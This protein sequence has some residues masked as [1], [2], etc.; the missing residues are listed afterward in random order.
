MG[1]A[2]VEGKG[3]LTMARESR[4]ARGGDWRGEAAVRAE[5]VDKAMKMPIMACS[6]GTRAKH[7]IVIV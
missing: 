2:K 6:K 4:L 3:Q 7:F 1:I 5:K